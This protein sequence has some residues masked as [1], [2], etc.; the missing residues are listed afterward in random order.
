MVTFTDNDGR[1]MEKLTNRPM[2]GMGA[3]IC[4]GCFYFDEE[5]RTES[6]DAALDGLGQCCG[7]TAIFQEVK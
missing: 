2:K 7:A 5:A 1:K 4:S 6:C 3:W